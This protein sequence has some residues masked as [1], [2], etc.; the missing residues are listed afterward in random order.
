MKTYNEKY[1]DNV[2]PNSAALQHLKAV[3]PEYFTKDDEFDL[4]KLRGELKQNNIDELKDGYQLNFIGKDYARR[5][6]GELPSTVIVPD[7]KQN[8]GEGKD[9]KNL[10]FTGDNL[11]VLRHLQTAYAGKIDVIYIDPPYN[12]GNGDFVYPDNFEYSDDKLKEMFGLDDEEVERLK[13][14]QGKSSHSAWLTF[15]YPRLALAKKLLSDDGVIFISIDDNEQ[16]NLS[17]LMNELFGEDNLA[18]TIHCQM[19]TT[20]GM[21]VKAAQMGNIVKNAEYVL[22]YTK[23]GRRNIAKVPI[24]D[25]RAKYDEHYSLYAKDNGEICQLSEVYNFHFPKD[26]NN[27]KPLTLAEAYEKSDDFVMF[28]RSHLANI[29]RSHLANIVRSDKVGNSK[30]NSNLNT[31]F[32]IAEIHAGR[33]YLLTKDSN[34]N[35]KQ[36]LRLKDSWGIADDYEHSE[37]LRKIRG[38]WW[39]GFYIDMGNISKE[40]GVQFSNGKKPVRL[41]YQLL[42]MLGNTNS[43]VLDFFA[44]SATTADAVMQLNAEDGGHRKFIMVQLPEKT[45]HVNKNGKEEPTKGGKAAYDAGFRSIDEIS[46]ERI[47]RAES[48]IREDHGLTLPADFDGS[49][50]HYR[51]VKPTKPTLESIE[52]FD[53]K[54]T[55]LFTDMLDSF[56]SE[57]LGVPSSTTGEQT[58]LTTYLLKD[59]Y[60]LD[61]EI[62]PIKLADYTARL[63]D[64]RLYLIHDG[65]NSAATKDL[66]NKIGNHEL[67]VTTVILFGYSFNVADLREIDNGLK[68]LDPAVTLYKRY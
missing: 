35:I 56:S 25:H 21:K 2:K 49:F 51:V 28:V 1:N 39:K 31:G 22:C 47:R 46:R 58:I 40:G 41:I 8:Q 34:G 9:S 6:V 11:E 63:V 57:K 15:M 17:L 65:W 14:I 59:G 7:E 43:I 4:D 16:A 55:E 62:Q 52:D 38:N 54:T 53:P 44:G 32:W 18:A 64:N 61:V 66:L 48:K 60:S 33:R 19:S 23:N 3:L 29:V 42:K 37:G 5:Q 36:L 30:S 50:K 13:S 12:T 27:K 10:F 45:Y 67:H 20:Q 24:Y 26:M 68:N